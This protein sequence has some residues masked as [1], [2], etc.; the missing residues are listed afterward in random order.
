MLAL[1]NVWAE[2]ELMK[3]FMGKGEIVFDSPVFKRI[4]LKGTKALFIWCL[5]KA[6]SK[7]DLTSEVF[8]DS[9]DEKGISFGLGGPHLSAVFEFGTD[10][11]SVC[12]E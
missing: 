2:G 6:G 1:K 8:L 12:F 10:V 9:F 4:K 5:F 3:D 11:C 7:V